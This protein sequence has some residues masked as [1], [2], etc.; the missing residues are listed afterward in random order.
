MDNET[1]FK[2]TNFYYEEAPNSNAPFEIPRFNGFLAEKQFL[3]KEESSLLYKSFLEK[4]VL[5]KKEIS[6]NLESKFSNF[7]LN[8]YRFYDYFS[9]FNDSDSKKLNTRIQNELKILAKI[10]DFKL[11]E[12]SMHSWL[13]ILR[14]G[15]YVPKHCH[16][17]ENKPSLSYVIFL[18]DS[19]TTFNLEIPHFYKTSKEGELNHF[20]EYLVRP[21]IGQM[22]AFP[23]WMFHS[24]KF[25]TEEDKRVS[26]AGTI[27]LF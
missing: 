8:G 11:K 19:E 4:E 18:N 23:S 24:T 20:P 15:E 13:N 7:I 17:L 10:F 22:I 21:N 26:L 14:K 2:I 5:I 3:S 6:Q 16:I 1:D 27:K 25:H 9:L 12:E